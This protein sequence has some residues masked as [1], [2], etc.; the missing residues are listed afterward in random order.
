MKFKCD[1]RPNGRLYLLKF[2]LTDTDIV[3]KIGVTSRDRC[4]DRMLEVLKDFFDKFRYIPKCVMLRDR[5]C[6]GY[7]DKEKKLH[8]KYKEY[9]VKFNKK[10]GGSTE[11]FADINE[12]ELL[13]EWNNL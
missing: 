12:K 4:T 3:Y 7:L 11:F 13:D 6:I 1:R 5:F 8:S 10:F 2:Y 9:N